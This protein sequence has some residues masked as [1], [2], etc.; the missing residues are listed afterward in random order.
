MKN[1]KISLIIPVY[2]VADYLEETIRSVTN[3]SIGFEDN[4]ELILVNDGSTDSSEEICLRYAE[5]YPDNV[6]YFAQE[7]KGVSA[8]RNLGLDNACGEYV[9]FVDGDDLLEKD[10]LLAPKH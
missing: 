7:N 10:V 6:R 4:I 8:A 9:C 5:K 1:R 2:N 3:Q